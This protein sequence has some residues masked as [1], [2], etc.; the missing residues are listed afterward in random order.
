MEGCHGLR[1]I[2]DDCLM[3]AVHADD[4]DMSKYTLDEF[5]YLDS[6]YEGLRESEYF[7]NDIIFGE[8][9][10]FNSKLV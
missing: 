7:E 5:E 8:N 9:T 3:D 4:P 6:T 2:I 10:E 1:K